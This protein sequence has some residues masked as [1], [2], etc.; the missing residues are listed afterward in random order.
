MKQPIKGVSPA[1]VQEAVIMH[2][3]PSIS[4]YGLGRGI[5]RLLAIRWPDVY[6]FRMGVLLAPLTIPF[7]L[8]LYFYR[9]F[10]KIPGVPFHGGFYRLTNRRVLQLRNEFRFVD[11]PGSDGRTKRRLRFVFGAE[12]KSVMLDQFETIDIERRPGQEWFDAGDMIFRSGTTERFR[13]NGVSRPEAF[14]HACMKAR[15]AYIGVKQARARE[16]ELVG[17]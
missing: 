11:E 12:V 15:M 5:G 1:E 7:A 17:A 9:L 10:P 14:R 8:A 16:G 6:F 2:A 3:W 4:A 13:L